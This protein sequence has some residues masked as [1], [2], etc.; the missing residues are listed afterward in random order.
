MLEGILQGLGAA[1]SLQNL[2]MVVAGCLIVVTDPT[3]W[4]GIA[5]AVGYA[6]LMVA[7]DT[8][9]LYQQAAPVVCVI[10]A[11]AIPIEWALPAVLAHWFNP[12]LGDGV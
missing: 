2:I 10:A 1:L 4:L 6:Q 8:V 9:R 3:L 7:T 11:L 5:L 12:W